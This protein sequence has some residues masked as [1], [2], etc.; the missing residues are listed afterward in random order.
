MTDA[1]VPM[2]DIPHLAAVD[3][4][5][6]ITVLRAAGIPAL[7]WGMPGVGKSSMVGTLPFQMNDQETGDPLWVLAEPADYDNFSGGLRRPFYYPRGLERSVAL[8]QNEVKNYEKTNDVQL[9]PLF[10]PFEVIIGSIS[11][12]TEIM[13]FPS[14]TDRENGEAV[15]EFISRSWARNCLDAN[16]G[17]VFLDELTTCAP[18]VQKTMLQLV[19]GLRAGDVTLPQDTYIIAAANPVTSVDAA[20]D[21]DP[22]L[23]NRFAHLYLSPNAGNEGWRTFITA[24]SND[25]HDWSSIYRGISRTPKRYDTSVSTRTKAGFSAFI[26]SQPTKL[27]NENSA[28]TRVALMAYPTARSWEAMYKIAHF[29]NPF[30]SDSEKK[31]ALEMMSSILGNHMALPIMEFL[32]NLDLPDPNEVLKNP[33]AKRFDPEEQGYRSDQVY[34]ITQAVISIA[35]NSLRGVDNADDVIKLHKN[36][37]DWC[38]KIDQNPAFSEMAQLF[39][40][41]VLS[42]HVA[43]QRHPAMV[44]TRTRLPEGYKDIRM[45]LKTAHSQEKLFGDID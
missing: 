24:M 28:S 41:P 19:F 35:S 34:A 31:F 16:R 1:L 40:E 42:F 27:H 17:V 25:T 44:Q 4:F 21:L 23:A 43:T 15:I 45:V 9:V 8:S 10:E 38:Q 3:V 36:C 6:A 20:H 37:V 29:I 30:G 18:A 33:H 39:L 13:G 26:K 5:K 2:E 12:P 11:D 32:Q 7:I 14:R 22:A